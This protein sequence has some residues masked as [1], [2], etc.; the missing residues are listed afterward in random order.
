MHDEEEDRQEDE[1]RRELIHN[2]NGQLLNA[3]KEQLREHIQWNPEH[4]IVNV[5]VLH[6]IIEQK[7]EAFLKTSATMLKGEIYA[8]LKQLERAEDI[9]DFDRIVPLKDSF[10]GYCIRTGNVVWVDDITKL[11][12][13]HPLYHEYRPF[14]YVSV[15]PESKPLAEYVFPIRVQ[16]GLSEAILGVVNAEC[17]TTE[18]D[19]KKWGFHQILDL[20]FKLLDAHGP[21]LVVAE[22]IR[23]NNEDI[24]EQVRQ[25]LLNAH[26]VALKATRLSGR[27][28]TPSHENG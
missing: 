4:W 1:D 15:M 2:L 14:E 5:I 24:N 23:L 7:E 22:H 25:S 17:T 21:F 19:F 18:N 9:G 20:V 10:S 26:E 16:I 13:E 6:R 3:L 8:S 27:K 11:G 12:K 28:E